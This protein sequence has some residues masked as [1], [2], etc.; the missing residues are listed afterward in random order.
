MCRTVAVLQ[1]VCSAINGLNQ[2]LHIA[3]WKAQRAKRIQTVVRPSA[4]SHMAWTLITYQLDF[5][6]L[7]GC[8]CLGLVFLGR[9]MVRCERA[10]M[11]SSFCSPDTAGSRVWMRISETI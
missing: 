10:S 4:D 8:C 2:V 3:S 7:A 11:E 6:A 9:L 1:H 5:L